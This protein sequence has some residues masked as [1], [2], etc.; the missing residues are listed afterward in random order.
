[1]LKLK[2][3]S[4]T[5]KIVIRDSSGNRLDTQM[6]ELRDEKFINRVVKILIEKWDAPI[7][8]QSDKSILDF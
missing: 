8:L 3:E 7:K 2:D 1:M 6:G 5:I 4:I